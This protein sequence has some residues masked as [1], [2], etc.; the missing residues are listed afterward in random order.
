MD[1][2]SI[3]LLHRMNILSMSLKK[4]PFSFAWQAV[5]QEQEISCVCSSPVQGAPDVVEKNKNK[6]SEILCLSVREGEKV[7]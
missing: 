1:G 6:W 2:S 3:V 4:T 7:G 5:F